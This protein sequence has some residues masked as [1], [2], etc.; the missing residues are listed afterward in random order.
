[1]TGSA[2]I[3]K[4]SIYRSQKWAKVQEI[5]LKTAALSIQSLSSL[6][7]FLPLMQPLECSE[8]ED[9]QSD[10]SEYGTDDSTS[11]SSDTEQDCHSSDSDNNPDKDKSPHDWGLTSEALQC[12]LIS[13][14]QHWVTDDKNTPEEEDFRQKAALLHSETTGFIMITVD[15]LDYICAPL[16]YIDEPYVAVICRLKV[17]FFVS[18]NVAQNHVQVVGAQYSF[19]TTIFEAHLCYLRALI[20]QEAVLLSKDGYTETDVS[21][22]IPPNTMFSQYWHCL[23]SSWVWDDTPVPPMYLPQ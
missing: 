2:L 22:I 21:P 3:L 6:P 19:H 8:D 11:S 23:W 13:F 14:C 15:D 1:M 5:D 18:W 7:S 17:G 4:P 20:G 16:P 9:F 10:S 12:Q